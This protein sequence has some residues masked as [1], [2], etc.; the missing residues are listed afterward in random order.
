MKPDP[1]T[2]YPDYCIISTFSI[3]CIN[4][5]NPYELFNNIQGTSEVILVFEEWYKSI[6]CQVNEVLPQTISGMGQL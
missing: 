3:Q 5:S 4:A 1:L 2:N 6:R